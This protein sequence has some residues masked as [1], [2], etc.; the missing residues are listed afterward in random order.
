MVVFNVPA[1]SPSMVVTCTASAFA[2]KTGKTLTLGIGLPTFNDGASAPCNDTAGSL[3][4]TDTFQSNSTNG[5]WFLT[6]KDFTNA[7]V[8]DEG[9]PEPNSTGDRM[10]IRIPKGG[11]V[12]TNN[13]PC[14]LVF[15]PSGAVSIGGTYNDAGTLTIKGAKVPI[16]MTGPAFCGPASQTVTVTVTYKLSPALFDQG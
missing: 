4:F 15:A 5:A 16:S 6:E 12:D 7:G 3:H 11:L 1:T 8:G 13:W 14:T 9:L 10:A 2:G